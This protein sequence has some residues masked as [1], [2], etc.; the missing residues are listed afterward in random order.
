[1]KVEVVFQLAEASWPAFL[2]APAGDIVEANAAAAAYFGD[3]L[4]ARQFSA[5]GNCGGAVE[6]VLGPCPKLSAVP[7]LLEF[8]GK[9]GTV[10]VFS[11]AVAPLEFGS[12]KYFLFQL[13]PV[14]AAAPT[15]PTENKSQGVE[16][17]P[18]HKQR[19]D[20][21]MQLTRTVALD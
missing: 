16:I 18:S 11:T 9:Q 1:M 10:G 13:F 17:N 5:L 8:V 19:L 3:R 7:R 21:A 14:P 2:V 12:Q 4:E 6:D 20:C 15:L